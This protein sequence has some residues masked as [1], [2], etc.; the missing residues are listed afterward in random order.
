MRKLL[1]LAVGFLVIEACLMRPLCAADTAQLQ[2]FGGSIDF[3][4]ACTPQVDKSVDPSMP[5]QVCARD[6][7]VAGGPSYFKVLKDVFPDLKPDG[8]ATQWKKEIKGSFGDELQPGQDFELGSPPYLLV[9]EGNEAR[10]IIMIN[11]QALAYYRLKPSYELLDFV[12]FGMDPE[13]KSLVN[14]FGVFPVHPG[15][16]LFLFS[17]WHDNSSESFDG[18]QLMLMGPKE[19][20]SVYDGPSLYGY[21][22]GD[23]Q[24]CREAQ[25]FHSLKRLPTQHAGYSDLLLDVQNVKFCSPHGKEKELGRKT[26]SATLHWD[27]RKGKYMGGSKELLRLNRRAGQ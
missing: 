14:R 2:V 5:Y 3:G 13:H 23:A 6:P 7:I 15:Q 19:L 1:F 18:Y 27:E 12:G 26:F 4:A 24:D 25:D 17:S 21:R 20:R 8:H 16:Y 10:L 11:E 9:K 22:Y